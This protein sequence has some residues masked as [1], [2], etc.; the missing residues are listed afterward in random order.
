MLKRAWKFGET[1]CRG[2]VFPFSPSYS[3]IAPMGLLSCALRFSS[4]FPAQICTLGL[5][6]TYLSVS[7]SV[8][9]ANPSIYLILS[10]SWWIFK[11]YLLSYSCLLLPKPP[12]PTLVQQLDIFRS[13][14]Q[15]SNLL[16]RAGHG[17]TYK[18]IIPT[19]ERQSQPG[20]CSVTLS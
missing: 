12:S 7:Q 9:L 14:N 3:E 20:L 16:C 11:V 1:S 8:C 4:G 2:S 19:V 10:K 18:P 13:R 15:I 6:I 5:S 17:G